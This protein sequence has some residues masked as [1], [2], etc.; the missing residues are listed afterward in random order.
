[1]PRAPRRKTVVILV[2]V[3]VSPWAKSADVRREVRS[4]VNDGCEYGTC[5]P[6]GEEVSLRIR[7]IKPL[8]REM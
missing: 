2:T 8:R 1:M 7:K 6:D 3:D 5:G 4:R